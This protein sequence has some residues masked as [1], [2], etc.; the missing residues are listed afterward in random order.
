MKRFLIPALLVV[1]AL[2]NAQ[3]N[4]ELRI[5]KITIEALDVYSHTEADRGFFY[6]TASRLHIETRDSVIR[7]FLLFREG[8]VFNPVRLEET[9]RNLRGQHYLNSASVTALPPPSPSGRIRRF[10]PC[11]SPSDGAW[12]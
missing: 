9:E 12:P 4:P 7:K 3:T 10:R 8:D 5:G 2:S 1:A 11:K 6:R